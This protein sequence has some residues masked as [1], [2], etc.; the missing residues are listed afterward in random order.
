[1]MS[2]K[3]LIKLDK[4]FQYEKFISNLRQSLQ[5]IPFWIEGKQGGLGKLSLSFWW[6]IW[7]WIEGI[8]KFPV[9]TRF[10]YKD[11]FFFLVPYSLS[12]D[13]FLI[14]SYKHFFSFDEPMTVIRKTGFSMMEGYRVE[15][16]F[17]DSKYIESL[18][19]NIL[20]SNSTT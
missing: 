16:H 14:F 15:N 10:E 4:R 8:L 1:M 9:M 13:S 2:F 12:L 17:L 11:S 3:T 7:D 6:H 18:L 20:T 5:N 19:Q